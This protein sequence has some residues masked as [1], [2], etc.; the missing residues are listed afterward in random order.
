MN[1]HNTSHRATEELAKIGG[2]NSLNRLGFLLFFLICGLS[3]F[4]FRLFV[5]RE[6]LVMYLVGISLV[7]LASAVVLRQNNR[8]R[9]YFDVV[10]AFFLAAFVSV[11]QE[12]ALSLGWWSSSTMFDMVAGTVSVTLL[13]AI[14]IIAFTRIT[15]GDMASIY[16]VK[17]RLWLGLVVGLAAF[18]LFFVTSIEGATTLFAGK[19]LSFER[20]LPWMPWI[21]AFVLSNGLR[22][23][24]WFRGLFLGR[25]ETFVG[26]RTANLLQAT[27]FSL[28]HVDVQYTP[29]LLN[30]LGISFFLGLAFGFLIQRTR[31]LLGAILFHA[32][33]DVPVIIGIF[34]NL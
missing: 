27:V 11:L 1:S 3:I 32:G 13:V 10:F 7:F 17:G 30:F 25:F 2:E 29:E 22:E 24:L 28:A 19:D 4:V 34:S 9:R 14:P 21:M 26:S 8:L 23:E 18:I 31:S 16:L 12:M 15:G 33:A 5:P 20:V 6:F